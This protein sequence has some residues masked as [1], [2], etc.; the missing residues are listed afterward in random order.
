M[1][2]VVVVV[3]V[4]VGAGEWLGWIRLS[5]ERMRGEASGGAE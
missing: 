2:V 3:V 5:D 4:V 1:V